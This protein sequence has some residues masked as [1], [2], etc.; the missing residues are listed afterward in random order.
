MRYRALCIWCTMGLVLTKS[1][2]NKCVILGQ[3]LTEN[4]LRKWSVRSDRCQRRVADK[5]WRFLE[6]NK[7]KYKQITKDKWSTF[8]E[9]FLVYKDSEIT[10]PPPPHTHPTPPQLVNQKINCTIRKYSARAFQRMVISV[11]VSKIVIFWGQYLCAALGDKSHHQS[12]KG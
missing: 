3:E 12:L 1:F 10:T 2:K 11:Y 8:F 9:G 5:T 6:S 4:N 7:Y